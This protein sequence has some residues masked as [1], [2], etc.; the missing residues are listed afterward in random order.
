MLIIDHILAGSDQAPPTAK[1]ALLTLAFEQRQKSRL[2]TSL[3]DG[4]AVGLFLPRGTVLKQGDWLQTR[5]GRRVYV[6]AAAET[7][8]T[9]S[10]TEPVLL[11]RAAYHLGNRHVPLQIALHWLRY[12]HDHVLDAM[13]RQLGL[14]VSVEQA[15]FQPESGA[16]GHGHRHS[17]H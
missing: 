13:V 10:S 17:S 9:A 3:D 15:P 16:Y 2:R 7:V 5:D 6:R 8:S 12:C 4:T 1:S 11:L 14:S